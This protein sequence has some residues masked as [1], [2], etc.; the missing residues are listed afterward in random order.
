MEFRL[1][2]RMRIKRTR[3]TR[4]A[5]A[6]EGGAFVHIRSGKHPLTKTQ[7]LMV[8]SS[9]VADSDTSPLHGHCVS[10]D[11]HVAR[12]VNALPRITEM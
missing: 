6:P 2:N 3:S 8:P 9:A 10:S 1:G 4:K 7:I 11:C 12:I 5:L